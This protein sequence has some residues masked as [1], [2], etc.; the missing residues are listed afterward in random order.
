MF[1]TI[2]RGPSA[3]DRA[4][5]V[6][7]VK[8]IPGVGPRAAAEVFNGKTH[9]FEVPA[10]KVET[11][12][13]NLRRMML[14]GTLIVQGLPGE[15][16]AEIKT[17][18]KEETKVE[19]KVLNTGKAISGIAAALEEALAN[20][21]DEDKVR[22]IVEGA[23]D[24]RFESIPSVTVKIE[25]SAGEIREIKGTHHPMFP[26][27]LR[28]CNAR[29]PD[30]HR[31]NV[32]ITGPTASGKTTAARQVAEALGLS[33][34]IHGAV[35]MDFKLVGFVDANGSY[36]ETGFVKAFRNG[37]VVLLDEVDSYEPSPVLAIQAP[38]ANG[39][40]MLPNGEMVERHRDCV[41]IAAGNTW[42]SGAT[43]DFVGRNKLD[44]AFLSRFATKLFW[45][46]DTALELQIS[47]NEAWVKRVQAA[48]ARAEKAGLKHTIDPRHSI[49]GAALI[50]TGFSP[51]EVANITYL[52]GLSPD[53]RKI[54]EGV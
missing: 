49:D 41:V 1:I 29:R 17:E 37:G 7:D 34:Y 44:A 4:S 39:I 22:A 11:T 45:P 16:K 25:T 9:A 50:A 8:F 26:T 47:G 19:S 36:H 30:G 42:G 23:I 27:L 40:M 43:A 46:R 10:E 28:V 51:D 3:N 31:L 53:Q 32:W 12:T 2:D 20:A 38:L 6:N 18:T 5:F 35:D 13:R 48:R 54:V 15:T 21:V 24:R 52:A 33:L 14:D